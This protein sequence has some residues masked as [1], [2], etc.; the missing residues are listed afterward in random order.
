MDNEARD[1]SGCIQSMDNQDFSVEIIRETQISSGINAAQNDVIVLLHAETRLL[2]GAISGMLRALQDNDSA[3][4]G[5][6]GA[7]YD[8]SGL[9]PRL[10]ELLHRIWFVASGICIGDQ[11]MFFR[12]GAFKRSSP[13]IKS[14]ENIELS[15]RMK[16]TGATVFV[17][18]GVAGI[19]PKPRPPGNRADFMKAFFISLRY[20]TLRRLGWLPRDIADDYPAVPTDP[21]KK[22]AA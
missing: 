11:V 17:P 7:T 22:Q 12:R 19:S 14:M 18:G 2:P 10:K 20:L 13:V 16:E 9:S 1:I 5:C 21:A 15:L 6:F 4:G 3:V 8:G